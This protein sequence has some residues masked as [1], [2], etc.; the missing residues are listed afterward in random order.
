MPL[1]PQA[2]PFDEAHWQAAQERRGRLLY[3]W[4]SDWLAAQPLSEP[5]RS[6]I[7]LRARPGLDQCLDAPS[8]FALCAA[9][10]LGAPLAYQRSIGIAATLFWAAADVADDVDDGEVQAGQTPQANDACALLFLATRALAELG[11][12]FVALGAAYGL[13]MAGGQAQDLAATGKPSSFDP[14]AIADEKAGAELEFFFHL[15]AQY[16]NPQVSQ[17]S[18]GQ[19]T[20]L[21]AGLGVALQIF[22]DVADLYISPQS[23][24][25]VSG[26][27]TLPIALFI[28]KDADHAERL[29][30]ADRQWPDLQAHLRYD[31]KDAARE[32][33]ASLGA[34]VV[35]AWQLLAK[36]MPDAE[37]LQELVNWI[38]AL[39]DVVNTSLESLEQPAPA[40]LP[41]PAQTLERAI[42]F[43]N[44][45]HETERHAWGLFGRKRV[46]GTLFT[47]VF[48][49]AALR[50][51]GQ[52][53]ENGLTAILAMRDVDGWRYYPHAD[54]I[55]PDAD[56]AGLILGHFG[57]AL[58]AGVR[59]AT[60]KQLIGAF[61]GD[62]IHTW[63]AP[64]VGGIAWDGDNCL[65][66]LANAA[67]GLVQTGFGPQVPHAVWN[68]MTADARARRWSS[69][70]YTDPATRYFVNRSLAAA[71]AQHLVPY[72]SVQPVR[73]A[74]I[75]EINSLTRWGGSTSDSMLACA[76]DAL[77]LSTWGVAPPASLPVFFGARQNID[78]SWPAEPL[79][80]I[81]GIDYRPQR[82]GAACLTTSIVVQALVTC[83]A[84]R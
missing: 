84:T 20:R 6:R 64:A 31:M 42:D 46:E 43:L 14:Q 7:L 62:G 72:E 23:L 74:L 3:G 12:E 83:M 78:G 79:F 50:C 11:P 17:P 81:P 55:P 28:K 15:A 82:W 30:A 21:G 37:P 32:A 59:E 29:L 47:T 56:D 40:A 10:S 22:S 26:K 41:Q 71:A 35:E 24:D 38:L 33:L 60:A 75:G 76:F 69:P 51:A 48:T 77:A 61:E 54:E 13:R 57:D 73:K 36:Q 16:R 5:L 2:K 58:P 39:L 27:H 66:T 45:V 1:Q 49:A 80:M 65:A 63:M 34:P 70:F 68:R 18:A 53:W 44:N 8:T 19:L 67:W 4:I 25:L 9:E 52:A